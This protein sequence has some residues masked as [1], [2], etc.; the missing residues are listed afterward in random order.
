MPLAWFSLTGLK[1][2]ALKLIPWLVLIVVIYL[3][4]LYAQH[5]WNEALEAKYN[6]GVKDGKEAVA[7]DYA[8]KAAQLRNNWAIDKGK[9]EY[10]AKQKLNAANADAAAARD[11]ADSLQRTIDKVRSIASNA[12][13]TVTARTST[14]KAVDLLANM[15]IESNR[16]A[17]TYADFADRAFEAGR[18]CEL[19]YDAMRN[20]ILEQQTSH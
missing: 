9:I 15:L 20:R 1:Q 13:V 16:R 6:D 2:L 11:T 14:G 5:K 12:G 18:T 4:A 17:N 8:N 7:D 19:Q 10:E 3:T